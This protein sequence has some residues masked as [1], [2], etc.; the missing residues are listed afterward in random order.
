MDLASGTR[1]GVYEIQSLLGV[2]AMGEVYRARDT[3]LGR[4]VAIKILPRAF[5]SDSH[6]LARFERE[7]RVMATLSHPN[8][9]A[10]YGV[11]ER[12]DVCALV[13]ELVEGETLAERIA[14]ERR[15][16][17]S[18]GSAERTMTPHDALTLARQIAEA[19][20]VAHEK[21]I[22][23]RDLKP[24]NIMITADG[25]VK[26]L[27][28]SLAKPAIDQASADSPTLTLHDTPDGAVVGTAAY[29]S[30]EQARGQPVD[31]RT[32]IWA[33][34]CVLYEMLTGRAAF[35][36]QTLSDTFVAIID[37]EP[38]W[39]SLPAAVPPPIRR[40]LQRALEKDPKRRLRD[41]GDARVE[42]D[43]ALQGR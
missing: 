5:T 9:A 40:L 12:G 27:D 8:I 25:V 41:I 4:N 23:H 22:V 11:E 24:A 33:F 38:P 31:K 6:R 2:G 36:G 30:P 21:G 37:R 32:D 34:G 20:D 39:A 14:R 42:I 7:A 3:R 29:M 10:I 18:G 16:L 1:L 43:E 15:R 13:L 17:R 28:F 35:A 26:V 19:L